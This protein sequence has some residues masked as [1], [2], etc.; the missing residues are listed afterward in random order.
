MGRSSPS[1]VPDFSKWRSAILARQAGVGQKRTD[2]KIDNWL[3]RGSELTSS[4]QKYFDALLRTAIAEVRAKNI[5]VFTFGF[6]HDHES[7]A[8]S[9]CVDTEENSVRS[10]QSMNKYNLR[11]FLKAVAEGNL[12][13][14]SLWQANVGRSLSLG[15]FAM[16]NVSRADVEESVIDERFYI[17]MVQALVAVQDEITT[18]SSNP[19]RLLLA[20]SS[21][22]SDVG[23]VWS[24]QG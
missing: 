2:E 8:V 21:E 13:H 22:N 19:E 1:L 10:V 5:S 11:Y 16:V 9:V 18:L 7:G 4:T 14:A 20:C 17:S 6:Y 3:C 23:Y 15:D 24:L 12:Q